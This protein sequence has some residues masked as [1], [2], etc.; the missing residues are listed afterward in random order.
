MKAIISCA[1]AVSTTAVSSSAREPTPTATKM[2]SKRVTLIMFKPEPRLGLEPFAD[3]A[4]AQFAI[5]GPG[6]RT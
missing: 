1:A 2:N 6:L 4:G 3:D 5:G